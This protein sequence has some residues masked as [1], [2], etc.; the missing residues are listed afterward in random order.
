MNEITVDKI[1]DTI[2]NSF[3]ELYPMIDI[4]N[5]ITKRGLKTSKIVNIL[6]FKNIMMKVILLTDVCQIAV[7]KSYKK[8]FPEKYTFFETPSLPSQVYINITDLDNFKDFS[9]FYRAFFDACCSGEIGCCS[10]YEEC[11]DLGHC[12]NPNTDIFMSCAYRR[13]LE[14]GKIFY[15]KDA[16]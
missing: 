4:Q 9:D 11:S 8:Y 13:N 7:S 3:S 6:L 10:K 14:Q 16:E 12:I 2:K 5:H 15:G 1:L